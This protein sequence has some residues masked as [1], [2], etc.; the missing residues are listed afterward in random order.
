[1]VWDRKLGETGVKHLTPFQA[2]DAQIGDEEQNRKQKKNKVG[3]KL[4][5]N[6]G[7]FC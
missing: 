5:G 2:I 3:G 7:T 1:M 6:G 4:K